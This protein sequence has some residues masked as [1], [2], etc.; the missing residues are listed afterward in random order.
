MA[1]GAGDKTAPLEFACACGKLDG[2]FTPEAATS[3]AH[4]AC[5][6]S[7]CRAAQLYMDQPDP[8]PGPVDL[9]QTTPD[10]LTLQG[11]EHLG[12]YRLSPRGTMRWY[13]TC[14]NTPLFNTATTAKVPFV[15]I[16]VA[17]LTT[18]ERIGP[19]IAQAFAP[20]PGGK[21]TH[22]GLGRVILKM[23]PQVLGT[24]ISGRWRQTP[25][26]DVETG[27]PVAT[28]K[29]PSKEERAALYPSMR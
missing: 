11:Q 27:K 22:K 29:I 3:G 20:K 7:D 10:A 13:A 14:C 28:A 19:V 26:F 12:L 2:H 1:R 23:L 24:R 15:G 8:A 18:P 25:F 6:C 5:Y 9:F 21:T 16:Q 4:V 17:R